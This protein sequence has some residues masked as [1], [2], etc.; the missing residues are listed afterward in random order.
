MPFTDRPIGI[1]VVRQSSMLLVIDAV[2][3]LSTK[4]FLESVSN[5]PIRAVLAEVVV[6]ESTVAIQIR[7]KRLTFVLVCPDPEGR[8][9]LCRR[10][11]LVTLGR[12]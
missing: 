2:A 6:A 11:R 10:G 8:C 1:G 5:L 12:R 4:S 7:R 9:R 3:Q